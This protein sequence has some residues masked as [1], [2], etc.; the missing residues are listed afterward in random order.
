MELF[1]IIWSLIFGGLIIFGFFCLLACLGPKTRSYE[2]LKKESE[3]EMSPE[4]RKLVRQLEDYHELKE[5]N[6]QWYD[7]TPNYPDDID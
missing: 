5:M 4:E 1:E 3:E 2:A 6:C 7:I